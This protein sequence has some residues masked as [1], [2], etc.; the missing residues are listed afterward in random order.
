M[1]VTHLDDHASPLAVATVPPFRHKEWR[2]LWPVRLARPIADLSNGTIQQPPRDWKLDT[3]T[4]GSRF[5]HS[6][7]CESSFP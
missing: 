2:K 3:W 7:R 1:H 5:L 6:L 4:T